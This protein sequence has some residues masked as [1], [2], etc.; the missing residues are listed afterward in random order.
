MAQRNQQRT[1]QRESQRSTRRTSQREPQRTSARSPQ[2]TRRPRPEQRREEPPERDRRRR[3][4]RRQQG[5]GRIQAI[6]GLRALAIVA[7]MLYHLGVGW[8]PSGHMGVVL[9]LVL[10]GYVVTASILKTLR[11]DGTLAL[12]GL[13]LKR[14]VRVWP[15][16][17]LMIAVTVAAC[18]VFNHVLLTKL[19][20]DLVPSLFL[21]NNLAAILRGASYFDNLG[22]T[23]PLTHLWYLGIDIQFFIVWS[24][25]L[26]VL[27]P[28]G[29]PNRTARITGLILAFV[30]VLLM[31]VLYDP[32]GDP[33]RVY[34]GPDTR[35]FAPL[36]GAWLGLAWPLG[37]RPLRLDAARHTVRSVPLSVLGP[38]GLLGLLLIMAFCPA[39]SPF[40]YRGGMALA[41]IFS[42]LLLAGILD[43]RLPLARALG[44]K[45]LVWLGERSFG[46]YLWHFPLFQLFR[47]S[48]TDTS[49]ALVILAVVL[50]FACA[51]F[52]LRFV[53]R[54]VAQGRV[55]FL[56]QNA[57]GR[58][59][60]P[61]SSWA[62]I[63][64]GMLALIVA[65]GVTGLL[66]IP[67]ATAVPEDAIRSTGEGAA[68]AVDLSKRQRNPSSNSN[69]SS[70]ST[71]SGSKSSSSTKSSSKKKRSTNVSA[72]SV[73][74][75]EPIVLTAS[76][77]SIDEGLYTPLIVADS[78][79]GD[80]ESYFTTYMPDGFLDSYVGRFPSQA[81]T[82][83]EQYID[84]DVVGDVVVVASFSNTPPTEK[85]LDKMLDLCD[86]RMLFLVNVR[87]PE[88]EEEQ[89]N[90][91]LEEY[92][93]SH[94]GVELI[95]WHSL[96]DSHDEWFYDD[97]THVNEKGAPEYANLIAHSIAEAFED[98]GGTVSL[99]SDAPTNTKGSGGSKVVDP[100]E[101]D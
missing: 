19:K 60:T 10:S 74:D 92:A 73:S 31:A 101:T 55:P 35:A 62:W 29:R 24:M 76:S 26:A 100:T 64:A 8:L 3:R 97:D 54:V 95:D 25:L 11:R 99:E 94:K 96:S 79:A 38:V 67:D 6:E 30:S 65:G 78:I 27:C 70:S 28:K 43:N 44:A 15:A 48:R 69:E 57:S 14:V 98:A 87:I 18:A 1:T 23:S 4:P 46:L 72:S 84:Q 53:E 89:I 50:S 83:L 56:P 21:V 49:V 82:T 17:A 93:S 51:E 86:G 91:T 39:M 80:A 63:P 58:R 2:H 36:L 40:L 5:S 59:G 61:P 42:L 7:I 32:N 52:S 13:W 12:P 20:P 33:T 88:S 90:E 75:D 81:V 66:V 68:T 22:G 47:V 16:M 45:P 85:E 41:A 37:G 77:K 9:F 34:Y 71:S